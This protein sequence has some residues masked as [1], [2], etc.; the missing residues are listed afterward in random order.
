MNRL[1]FPGLC[2]LVLDVP[3]LS[4]RGL[5]DPVVSN[6]GLS[7][8]GLSVPRLSDPGIRVPGPNVSGLRNQSCRAQFF[9]AIQPVLVLFGLDLPVTR[10]SQ[11]LFSSKTKCFF[12]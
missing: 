9:H 6:P 1:R 10:F 7:V 2:V 4:G 3:G 8:P 5:S 12:Y 11:R